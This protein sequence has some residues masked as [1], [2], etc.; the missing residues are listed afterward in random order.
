MQYP[1]AQG[2]LRAAGIE[3]T[4]ASEDL[5]EVGE[6]FGSVDEVED[7]AGVARVHPRGDVDQNQLADQFGVLVG[8]DDSHQTSV[9]HGDQWQRGNGQLRYRR[10]D[11]T[12]VFER[13]ARTVEGSVGVSVVG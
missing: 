9:G 6:G 1:S 11:V 10:R 2:R 13:R 8:D 4:R 7:V 12:G 5:I 3:C